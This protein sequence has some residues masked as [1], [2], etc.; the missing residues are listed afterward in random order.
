MFIEFDLKIAS[1]LRRERNVRFHDGHVTLL[2]S[3]G[4]S[5]GTSA[6]NIWALCGLEMLFES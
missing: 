5:S 4:A 2:R 1:K 6:I 3:A